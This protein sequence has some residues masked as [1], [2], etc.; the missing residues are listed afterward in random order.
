[1]AWEIQIVAWDRHKNVPGLNR[2]MES[3][4]SPSDNWISNMA[5][6]I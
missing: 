5:I 3:H 1:M 4:S 6:Q 2:L